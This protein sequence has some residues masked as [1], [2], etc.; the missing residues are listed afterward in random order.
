MI[1]AIHD[2]MPVILPP[3]SYHRWLSDLEP[4]PHDLLVP[5]PAGAMRMWPISTRVNTPRNDDP[6]I[7]DPLE[8]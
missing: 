5:Y 6:S 1:A 8:D 3:E 2:R 4:D 7:L